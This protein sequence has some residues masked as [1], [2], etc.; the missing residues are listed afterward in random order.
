V[1]N[2]QV[3]RKS[4]DKYS[5]YKNKYNNYKKYLNNYS[6]SDEVNFLLNKLF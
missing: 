3:P 2:I 5:A 6:Y 4:N 1:N